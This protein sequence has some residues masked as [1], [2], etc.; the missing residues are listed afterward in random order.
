MLVAERNFNVSHDEESKLNQS[1]NGWC[2]VSMLLKDV[3]ALE[4]PDTANKNSFKAKAAGQ[5]SVHY[6]SIIAML[7]HNNY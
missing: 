6:I 5:R 2:Y 7:P 4:G 1:I 3:R